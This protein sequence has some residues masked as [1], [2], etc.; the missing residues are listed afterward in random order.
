MKFKAVI[1]SRC[2]E[3]VQRAAQMLQ[4][5]LDMDTIY[6]G[7]AE[8]TVE[9]MC[10]HQPSLVLMDILDTRGDT[11]PLAATI[12]SIEPNTRILFY[13]PET[14]AAQVAPLQ[15]QLTGEKIAAFVLNHA[16]SFPKLKLAVQ[17]M[18]IFANNYYDPALR[19]LNKTLNAPIEAPY[20]ENP[21]ILNVQPAGNQLVFL[22]PAERET[23]G[24]LLI[25]LTD[26]AIAQKRNL[27]VRGVQSRLDRLAR[28]LCRAERQ[29]GRT[30]GSIDSCNHSYNLRAR[31]IFQAM[32]RGIFSVEDLIQMES[33]S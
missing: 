24:D 16:D 32:I 19:T 14:E 2:P 29:R 10:R 11:T 31:M 4:H 9:L 28:K 8:R 30:T 17:A 18:C 23:L 15:Q 25:G 5:T 1:I 6:V 22:T 12:W 7:S 26:K 33:A 21:V 27:S 3:F 13:V 20:I